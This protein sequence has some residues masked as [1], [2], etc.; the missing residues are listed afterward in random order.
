MEEE[1]KAVQEVAKTAGK[2]IDAA[3]EFGGFL[4]PLIKG[5]VEQAMKIWEDR[6][7]YMRWERQVRLMQRAKKF[8]GDRGLT[9]PSR[10]I[11]L[12]FAIPLLQ[13]AAMED[14]DYLQD[15]WAMLLVNAADVTSGVEIRRTFISILRDLSPFDALML[16]KI[17]QAS[18]DAAVDKDQ[19]IFTGNLPEKAEVWNKKEYEGKNITLLEEVELSLA[20]LL[21]LGCLIFCGGWWQ[22]H[23]SR[24]VSLSALGK[25]FIKACTRPNLINV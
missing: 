10:T 13:E 11:P 1:S 16:D 9:K 6:L 18:L 8:L 24:C 22:E 17:Y 25:A 21:R 12:S 23:D 15:H 19:R 5:P 4:A 7:K 2:G 20:N 3:R 14:D